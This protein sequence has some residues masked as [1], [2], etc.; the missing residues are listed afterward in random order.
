MKVTFIGTFPP[1]K[2]ISPYC[3]FLAK[4]LSK[5]V[6]LEII[7]F[8]APY[9]NF[10]YSGGGKEKL[11]T[12]CIIKDTPIKNIIKWYNPLS[13]IKTG[14][15]AKGSVVHIQHW[16]CYATFFY[17]FILPIL[18][19][20]GKKIVLSIHNITPH[21]LISYILFI[22]KIFNKLTFPYTDAFIIH[23]LRNK[24]TFIDLYKVDEEKIFIAG[25]GAITPY[26][27]IKGISKKD[28]REKLKL[29]L[30][31]K[32][33]L[34]IGYMWEYKGIDILLKSMKDVKSK[35]NNVVLLLAGQP[36]DDWKKYNKIIE[37]EKLEDVLIKKFGYIDDSELELYFASADLVVLPYKKRA[38]DTHGG[39]GALA[40]SFK[41]PLLVTD[42]GG[43]NEYVK[44]E[45]A[46]AK[47]ED[48]KDLANKIMNILTN[49]SLLKK[50][51]K[52]SEDLAKELTWDN[53]ADKTINAY[54]YVS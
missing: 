51:S 37:N 8:N 49:D 30:N 27:K 53:I 2:N 50:L 38:F 28:A 33:I 15:K 29:P 6:D 31:K 32:I 12:K 48:Y 44:D 20:R 42:V 43:L 19:I 21:V 16:A 34:N 39:Q 4:S 14:M 40:I 10:L 1:L 18:K 3:F 46:I 36:L 35:I 54:N 9:P 25:H 41:K 45:K 13:W 24:K 11:S 7:G 5:K 26:S 52:D 22:D 17:I 23:N 47:P